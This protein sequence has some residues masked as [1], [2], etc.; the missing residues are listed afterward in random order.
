MKN[1]GQDNETYQVARNKVIARLSLNFHFVLYLASMVVYLVVVSKSFSGFAWLYLLPVVWGAGLGMNLLPLVSSKKR[2]DD[3]KRTKTEK[4]ASMISF[5]LEQGFSIHSKLFLVIASIIAVLIPVNF[6][7]LNEYP[8][9][10]LFLIAWGVGLAAH[11]YSIRAYTQ[12][13][14]FKETLFNQYVNKKVK[15]N[16]GETT[17]VNAVNNKWPKA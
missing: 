7:H 4:Q 15:S 10:Y 2:R 1:S 8:R 16:L 6:S 5:F 3:N 13:L 9:L 11:Y 14:S 12:R 17:M